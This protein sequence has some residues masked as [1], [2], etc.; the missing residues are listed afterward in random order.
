MNYPY[1]NT[2]YNY[3]DFFPRNDEVQDLNK[4][5]SQRDQLISTLMQKVKGLEV[6]SESKTKKKSNTSTEKQNS[7]SKQIKSSS[8]SKKHKGNKS[9]QALKKCHPLQMLTREVPEDFKFTKAYATKELLY[10][11]ETANVFFR[12]L[13]HQMKDNNKIFGKSAP[14][15]PQCQPIAPI[16]S[17]SANVPRNMPL[18]F[19]RPDWF[20]KLNYA[21]RSSIAN[22]KQVAF[23][24]L[25]IVQ[26]SNNI[27]PDE[28]LFNKAFNE[29]YWE[30]V[31]QPYDL[32]HEGAESSGNN[33]DDDDESSE[34]NE[35][36]NGD[37][38]DLGNGESDE[39]SKEEGEINEAN[40]DQG[41]H[42]GHARWTQEA[43]EEMTDAF[44]RQPRQVGHPFFKEHLDT[45][46]WH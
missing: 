39:S 23:V 19:Y 33:D 20:N 30:A 18:D 44:D 31:T 25:S 5:L 21:Q 34:E 24:P 14:L 28:N 11:S 27:H 22:S 29:K 4:L 7:I 41:S 2:S 40:N 3:G 1:A 43:D 15:H 42:E 13:D 37:I 17:A 12:N 32:S 8:Q 36:S 6:K 16:R 35:Y 46:V 45:N 38:I 26:M 10:H 9:L